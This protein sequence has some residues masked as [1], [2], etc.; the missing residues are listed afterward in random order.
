MEIKK[1][2]CLIYDTFKDMIK[3]KDIMDNMIVMTLG[4]N[5]V[6]DNQGGLYEIVKKDTMGLK[7][8]SGE[9]FGMKSPYYAKL[10]LNLV[11]T[12]NNPNN[13]MNIYYLNDNKSVYIIQTYN[14]LQYIINKDTEL[15]IIEYVVDI[16]KENEWIIP[17]EFSLL[18]EKSMMKFIGSDDYIKYDNYQLII[19]INFKNKKI[20]AY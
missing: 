16:N 9:S 14:G 6:N 11:N 3:D 2:N 4:Y 5:T 10:L 18:N 17:K 8:E 13:I 1:R 19:K 20:I 12:N 15:T 7:R